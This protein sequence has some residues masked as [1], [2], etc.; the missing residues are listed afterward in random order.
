ML[1]TIEEF[2]QALKK[3]ITLFDDELI[4]SKNLL[5]ED[6]EPIIRN[7]KLFLTTFA[8]KFNMVL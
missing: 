7:I 8:T 1:C 4:K 5:A 6:I 3:S 2:K